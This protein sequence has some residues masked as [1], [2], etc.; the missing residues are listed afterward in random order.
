MGF[1]LNFM[2][3]HS[4]ARVSADDFPSRS[5]RIRSVQFWMSVGVSAG[6]MMMVDQC[7]IVIS[8]GMLCVVSL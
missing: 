5:A 3:R 8:R 2:L 4:V 7:F 6:A 1:I